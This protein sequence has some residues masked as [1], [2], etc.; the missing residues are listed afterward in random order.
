L[1][2]NLLFLLSTFGDYYRVSNLVAGL[3]DGDS[4]TLRTAGAVRAREI[5]N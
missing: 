2:V 3:S 4:Y 1:V 5:L